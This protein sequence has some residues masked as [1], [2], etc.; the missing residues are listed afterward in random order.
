MLR[1]YVGLA[2]ILLVVVGLTWSLYA[3]RHRF[4]RSDND[5]F[6]FLPDPVQTRFFVDVK[7]LRQ[8]GTLDQFFAPRSV[9][10]D[11]DYAAFVRETGFLYERDLDVLAASVG[12][13]WTFVGRG[14]FEWSRLRAYAVHHGGSC[15]GATC[16]TATGANRGRRIV[17][18]EIQPDVLQFS[19][20][21]L[22]SSAGRPLQQ[23]PTADPVWLRLDP[24]L[25]SRPAEL[26]LAAR[27]F[28][29]SMSQASR[30]LLSLGAAAEGSGSAFVLR[31]NAEFPNASTADTARKQLELQTEMLG[32]ELKREK[33]P[34]DP[35]NLTGLLT[36]GTFETHGD[37]LSGNWPVRY[38]LLQ[39]LR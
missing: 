13:E 25:L 14:R 19:T 4:V 21:A 39:A 11:A 6:A 37:T 24:L 8:S 20:G 10:Q 27:I 29:I 15:N 9:T 23:M 35:A 5:L 32:L 7:L 33:Q 17:F 38:E 1:K 31:L 3:W 28:A 36:K 18:R 30:V 12:S 26:P 16:T 2:A 34:P 22:P